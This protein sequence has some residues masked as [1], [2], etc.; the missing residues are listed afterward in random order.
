MFELG[1]EKIAKRLNDVRFLIGACEKDRWNENYSFL[2][3]LFDSHGLL[4]SQ[5]VVS[6]KTIFIEEDSIN[7]H[8][9]IMEMNYHWRDVNGSLLQGATVIGIG[10]HESKE[11][12]LGQA[13]DDAERCYLTIEFNL[14]NPA[15]KGKELNGI[16]IC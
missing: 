13:Y 2:R 3:N 14:R 7:K 10:I 5:N 11:R 9:T 6:S 4:L 1:E 16:T 15:P 8:M 12:S